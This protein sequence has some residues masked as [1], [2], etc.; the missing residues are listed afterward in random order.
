MSAIMAVHLILQ[1]DSA[2][3]SLVGYRRYNIIAPQDIGLPCLVLTQVNEDDE[4]LVV[5]HGRYPVMHLLVDCIADGNDAGFHVADSTGD[6]VKAALIDYRGRVGAFQVDGVSIDGVDHFDR[7]ESGQHHR[8]RIGFFMR[9][10]VVDE[11]E[12]SPPGDA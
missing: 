4:K 2:V 9:Y 10:R 8:R 1:A 3:T 12:D 11:P 5:G 6:A 7:G